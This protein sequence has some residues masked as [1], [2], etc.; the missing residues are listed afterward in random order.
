MK[1]RFYTYITLLVGVAMMSACTSDEDVVRQSDEINIHFTA[2]LD[3]MIDSRVISDGSQVDVLTFAAFDA[4]GNEYK[5]LRQTDVPVTAG[6]A[7]VTTRV[8]KGQRYRFVFWAQNSTCQAYTLSEDMKTLS[9]D[10]DGMKANDETRDAF[11]AV[12]EENLTA[13]ITD[14]FEREVTLRRPFAQVNFGTTAEDLEAANHEAPVT[15]SMITIE[16][17][18]YSQMNMLYGTVQNPV[19]VTLAAGPL[20]G[21]T[22]TVDGQGYEH[23]SMNYLLASTEKTEI[24]GVTMTAVMNHYNNMAGAKVEVDALPIQR[25]FRTNVVGRLLTRDVTWTVK[26]DATFGGEDNYDPYADRWDGTSVQEPSYVEETQTY[27][28]YKSS[29]LAW[30]QTHKPADGS[31]IVLAYKSL[32]FQNKSLAPLFGGARNITVDGN[33]FS[34]RNFK[35]E[36]A[37]SAGLIDAE[38][39]TVKNL[40]ISSAQVTATP[41]AQGNAYA[42]ALVGKASGT[43]TASN[44]IVSGSTIQGICGV[45]GIIGLAQGAVQATNLRVGTS[46]IL[47][48][49]APGAGCMGAF[50]GLLSGAGHNFTDCEVSNAVVRGFMASNQLP[51]GKFIGCLRGDVGNVSLVRCSTMAYYEGQNDVANNF[52]P[53]SDLIGGVVQ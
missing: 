4:E 26:I 47:N 19:G 43:F 42:G 23:I 28:V 16:N 11:Y 30:F 51:C 35:I 15:G 40:T 29:E 13:P 6:K 50:I 9:V 5:S 27:E 10:Y 53:Y 22:L 3:G 45:G 21:E 14:A 7:T 33:G 39:V 25:N 48:T 24:E 36:A 46:T 18:V 37:G 52:V 17:G 8:V 49:D 1:T 31:T 38:N 20:P 32:D 44:C 2:T 41:D 12:D 34:L